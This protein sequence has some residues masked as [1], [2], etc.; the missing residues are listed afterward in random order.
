TA[1]TEK[2]P[3][4]MDLTSDFAYV[5]LHGGEELYKSRYGEA[6]LDR[7]ADRLRRWSEGRPMQDGNFIGPPSGGSRRRDAFLFFGN[8]GK[9]HAPDT[10]RGL[11]LRLGVHP[12]GAPAPEEAGR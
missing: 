1:D 2:W 5:R 9:L 10:A 8:T 7:W 4:L 11:M 6:E 12:A 3:C